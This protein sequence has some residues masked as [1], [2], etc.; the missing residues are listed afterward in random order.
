MLGSANYFFLSETMLL[1][2]G[3]FAIKEISKH[4]GPKLYDFCITSEKKHF[5]QNLENLPLIVALQNPGQ[6][7]NQKKLIILLRK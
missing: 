3:E 1:S 2:V 4:A 5:D 7:K 6:Q